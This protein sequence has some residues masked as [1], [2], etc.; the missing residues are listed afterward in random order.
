MKALSLSE[1]SGF[2]QPG[3]VQPQRQASSHTV[4]SQQQCVFHDKSQV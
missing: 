1:Y 4:L 3:R 2:D